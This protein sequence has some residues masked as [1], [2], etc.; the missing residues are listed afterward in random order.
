MAERYNWVKN[1]QKAVNQENKAVLLAYKKG[2]KYS[3]VNNIP[4]RA[5][6]YLSAQ[7]IDSLGAAEINFC[8]R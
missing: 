5:L 3:S 7:T 6:S 8:R 1:L 4:Q 2:K